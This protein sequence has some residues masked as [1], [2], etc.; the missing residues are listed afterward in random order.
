MKNSMKVAVS[1]WGK[2]TNE[3]GV[4]GVVS[5]M[6]SKLEGARKLAENAAS[7]SS[8]G[9][10]QTFIEQVLGQ[11][12]DV[13]NQM[14][15]ELL[16]S[17]PETI[18]EMQSLYGELEKVSETGLDA[19]AQ[20]IYDKNGLATT[21]LKK[22]YTDTQA[23]LVEALAAE[24]EAYANTVADIE[25]TFT[26]A[27]AQAQVDLNKALVDAYQSLADSLVAAKAKYLEEMAALNLTAAQKKTV[28]STTKTLSGAIT[29]AKA[30]GATIN[31]N[32]TVNTS[33]SA[34]ANQIA[35]STVNAIKF[36]TP[37]IASKSATGATTG[38]GRINAGML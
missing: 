14:A 18:K 15:D 35:S 23:Q 27:L 10:S 16:N 8:A 21:E 2:D 20:Q 26:D 37:I 24:K 31:N 34:S 28:A 17:S 38:A 25:K 22:M 33:S 36:G 13:G 9:F 3:G 30:T 5:A 7:L 6:K 1:W 4:G 12:T 29:T 32:I 11:G 19:L